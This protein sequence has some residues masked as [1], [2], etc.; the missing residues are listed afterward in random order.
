MEPELEKEQ[1]EPEQAPKRRGRPS[2]L[3]QK[4]VKDMTA[5][6]LRAYNLLK[7]HRQRDREHQ[8]KLKTMVIPV[9]EVE[10]GPIQQQRLTEHIAQ[11]TNTIK[12]EV[13][14][15][16]RDEWVIHMIASVLYGLEHDIKQ[17][18]RIEESLGML[19]AGTFPDAA[20]AVSIKHI[21]E[22]P[23]ILGSATFA[24]LYK[25]FL[26]RAT[27]W[28]RT[29]Y[30]YVSADLLDI[31]NQENAGTYQPP[32]VPEVHKPPPP[33]ESRPIAPGVNLWTGVSS[34]A[35]KYLNGI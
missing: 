15:T 27:K 21:H 32:A 31:L 19:V 16:D 20:W 18:V 8:E 4:S 1:M 34:E 10:L 12:S 6:E 26:D 24:A 30:A 22:F 17:Q 7:K 3:G 29:N 35:M 14:L 5:E 2:V 11:L 25:K 9:D 23:A 33:I 28:S 13:T